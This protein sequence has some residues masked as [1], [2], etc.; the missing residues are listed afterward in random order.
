MWWTVWP[1]RSTGVPVDIEHS[2]GTEYLFVNQQQNGGKW[3]SLGIYSLIA[4]AS[5]T[6]TVASQPDPSSTCADAVKFAYL[7]GGGNQPPVARNDS[8][9]TTRDTAVSINVISND[10]DDAGIDRRFGCDRDLPGQRDCGS[11]RR[12]NGDVYPR[13]ILHRDGYVHVHGGRHPGGGIEHCDGDGDGQ[14]RKT[15]RRWR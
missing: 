6:V 9:V 13:G 12:R 11:K 1:S 10:T 15:S 5:Y 14:P 2:G 8:A 4:G 7:G 3:N